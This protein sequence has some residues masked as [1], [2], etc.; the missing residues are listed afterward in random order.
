RGE[1]AAER[2]TG[3]GAAGGGLA[4]I[5]A[6]AA[7]VRYQGGRRLLRAGGRSGRARHRWA[8]SARCG[9]LPPGRRRAAA[10][11]GAD[12]VLSGRSAL[13]SAAIWPYNAEIVWQVGCIRCDSGPRR[14]TIR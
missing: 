8:L 2:A 4:V 10:P 12:I 7:A 9:L 14:A 5:A 1:R 13:A 11:G 3:A 6:R